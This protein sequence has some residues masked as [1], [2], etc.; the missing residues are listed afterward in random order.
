MN[1]A[2]PI[3]PLGQVEV[4]PLRDAILA[5]DAA[6]WFE[7]EYRQKEYDVHRYTESIVMVFTDGSGW[8]NIEVSKQPGWAR[9]A[10]A[11]VPLMRDIIDSGY[12]AG[13]AIIRAMA[14]KL[15][16]GGKIKPHRDSHPSFLHGHRIHVPVTT[17]SRVRFMLDGRPYKLEV[18]QAYEINN[19]KLHSVMNKGKEDR[20]TFIFDYVPPGH[21]DRAGG[22]RNSP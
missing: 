22:R 11:A 8:P 3:K 15:L 10:A 6:A 16:A 7:Q 21:I 4:G 12:P 13:G 5:Q 17:N 14:A 2:M 9:L 20:I 1:I 19:Q 18:G